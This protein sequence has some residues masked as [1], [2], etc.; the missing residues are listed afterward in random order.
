VGRT[1]MAVVRTST[2]MEAHAEEERS[3]TI[4]LDG[5]HAGGMHLDGGCVGGVDLDGGGGTAS[6]RMRRRSSR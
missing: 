3:C 2:T 5:G 1:S 4:N 6:R